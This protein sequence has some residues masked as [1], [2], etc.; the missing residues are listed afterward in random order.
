MRILTIVFCGLYF[1]LTAANAANM[2][3]KS[4]A[5]SNGQAIPKLYSCDGKN[6]SPPLSW[7]N[8]PPNTQ[9][10]VLMLWSPDWP[11]GTM[12]KW[13][14]YNIPANTKELQEGDSNNLPEPIATGQNSLGDDLYRGPCPPVSGPHKYIFTLYALDTHLDMPEDMEAS[15]VLTKIQRHVLQKAELVGFF[16]H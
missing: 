2:T 10:F 11:Q 14:V 15:E 13:I 9:S 5:Y 3:L 4:K 7:A 6:I 8:V 12:Y 1:A 16:E